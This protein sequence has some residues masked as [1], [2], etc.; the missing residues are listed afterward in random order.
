MSYYL[1]FASFEFAEDTRPQVR[2]CSTLPQAL[3]NAV[4]PVKSALSKDK[5]S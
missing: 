2:S 5:Q 3:E 4:D 1:D